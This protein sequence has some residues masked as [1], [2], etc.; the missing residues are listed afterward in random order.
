MRRSR[1]W[2]PLALAVLV[3]ASVNCFATGDCHTRVVHYNIKAQPAFDQQKFVN[4]GHEPWRLEAESVAAEELLKY[5]GASFPKH[6]VAS[7]HLDTV[8]LTQRSAI[9]EW[10]SQDLSRRYI[11][12]LRKPSWRW[13]L[14]LAKTYDHMVWFPVK[15]TITTCRPPGPKLAK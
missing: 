9:F 14:E 2:S 12:E 5:E 13:F 11:I 3:I 10:K 15:T 4:D 6:D 1:W 8:V 7:V